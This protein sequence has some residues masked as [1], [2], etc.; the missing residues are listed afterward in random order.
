MHDFY[1]KLNKIIPLPFKSFWEKFYT[2]QKIAFDGDYD[3]YVIFLGGAYFEETFSELLLWKKINSY[4]ASHFCR[5]I[6][7]LVDPV[8]KFPAIKP[9]F[10][11]FDFLCTYNPNDV[12]KYGMNYISLPCVNFHLPAKI[13]VPLYDVHIRAMD[14]GRAALIEAV[15]EYLSE[16]GISC[17]FIINSPVRIPDRNG[18]R[19]TEERLSY[20]DMVLEELGANV[21]LEVVVPGLGSTGTLRHREAVMYGRKLLTNDSFYKNDNFYES[22]NIRYFEK[23]E[24][25]DIEWLKSC[26]EVSYGYQEEYSVERF[27]GSVVS[28]CGS[29]CQGVREVS[30]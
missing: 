17:N 22:G 9:W 8:D 24:D 15:W 6:L 21:I 30:E 18:I 27:C 4:A 19:Y 12:E 3:Y 25:I 7:Y 26:E 2:T 29:S 5:K 23:P 1:W 14:G 11:F 13:Q 10:K 28:V 16:R 20:K